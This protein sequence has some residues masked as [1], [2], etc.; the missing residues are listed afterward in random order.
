MKAILIALSSEANVECLRDCLKPRFRVDTV[1][2]EDS[3]HSKRRRR[4]DLIFVDSDGLPTLVSQPDAAPKQAL[5][6][7]RKAFPSARVVVVGPPERTRE[8]VALVKAGATDYLLYPLTPAE[9][10]LVTENIEEAET[11]RSE[12]RHLRQRTWQDADG[13]RLDTQSAAMCDVI[14]KVRMVAPTRSTVLLTGETGTGKGV[15]A[16]LLHRLSSRADQQFISVHCGAIPDTLIESELFG[17][18]KGS[19]TGAVKQKKGKF[20][21]ANG[22]TIF[23]DELG[24]ITSAAQ[25]KLLSVLQDRVVQR[26]GSETEVGVDVRIV[27]AT[28]D[29]L[30][31]EVEAGRFRRD[32][33]YRL[34]VFPIQIPA[35]RDRIE[36]I[37]LL[38]EFFLKRLNRFNARDVHDISST[39]LDAFANYEWP[40]NIREL[41]NLVERAFILET[42]DMLTP[43]SFPT[44]LFDQPTAIEQLFPVDFDTPLAEVRKQATE[45]IER[46]YLHALL[47][48]NQGRINRS[49]ADAGITERQ[50]HKLMTKHGLAKEHYKGAR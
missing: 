22:G 1:W 11:L 43:E 16:R 21:V 34:N 39:V 50:I 18:E 19:F 49:A 45:F 25:I 14:G 24:T 46:Q 27:A 12:V 38:V 41:E 44:E 10:E 33:Y 23:L 31:Q 17:H 5:D 30:K 42:S 26:V 8:T 13:V 6:A 35:L 40:G 37:P 36:D 47:Q 4:Y 2:P 15:L 32:L 20:E 3:L 28:N 29:N 7:L 9:V 48:R